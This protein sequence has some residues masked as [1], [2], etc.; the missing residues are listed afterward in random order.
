MSRQFG[1]NVSLC[2]VL[3]FAIS[4]AATRW[5]RWQGK[6]EAGSTFRNAGASAYRARRKLLPRR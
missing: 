1:R 6:S 3:I 2:L 5:R 4:P